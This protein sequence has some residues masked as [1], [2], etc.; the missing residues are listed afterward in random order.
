MSNCLTGKVHSFQSLGAVDGPGVR[1][2]VFMQGCPY[3]CP[4]CHNPDTKPFCGGEEY[5]VEE[6][7]KRA[8]RFKP[9]FGEKGGV[10]VSGGE[11]LA[12]AGFVAQLF[13]ALHEAGIN[14]AL[15]T[16][17]YT[18]MEEVKEVLRH[19][20]TVLCDIKFP[21]EDGYRKHIGAELET[22]LNFIEECNNFD[23]NTV[24]RHVVVPSLTDTEE[25]IR[26]ISSLARRVKRLDKIELLPFKKLCVQKYDELG[27]EFPLKDTPEC[28]N[29][30]IE[31]LKKVIEKG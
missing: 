20:D 29:E 27:L 21:T 6:I 24:I 8:V 2:V 25:N 17:G 18:V 15:D 11:P 1:F 26:Q 28:D 9:Y 19:T 31:K 16:A 14:T 22:V 7:V 23:I 10:T 4:Y 13:Q 12:Q 30:T 3:R 5:T